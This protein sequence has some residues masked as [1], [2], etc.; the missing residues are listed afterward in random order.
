MMKKLLVLMLSLM[1][2]VGCTTKKEEPVKDNEKPAEEVILGM[3]EFKYTEASEDATLDVEGYAIATLESCTDGDTATFTID[4]INYDTRF[5]AIDTPETSHPT[6]GREPWG[7]PAKEYTCNALTNATQIIIER[8]PVADIFDDYGRLLG[9]VWVDGELLNYKLVEDSLAFVK[10]LYAD[11]EY[12]NAFIQ[13][14][15]I[16]RKA[17]LKI[18]GEKDPD[19]DY[20]NSVIETTLASVREID[21]GKKVKVKGIV[22]AIIGQ[23]MY[24]QDGEH[25]IYIY[26]NK[27]TYRA[28]VVGNEIELTA[29]LAEYKGQLQLANIVDRK[30]EVLSEGN[31]LPPAFEITIDML[32]EDYES[33]LIVLRDLQVITVPEN[34]DTSAGYSVIVSDGTNEGIVRIDKYLDPTIESSFFEE[35]TTID[36]IGVLGQY[37]DEYQIMVTSETNVTRK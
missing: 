14:E 33:R 25:A 7:I 34:A 8:D 16:A 26:A 12:T 32:G 18:H 2:L 21:N 24:I 4:G 11:Y 19:Y 36:V 3:P 13:A 31:E 30:I 27:Y 17:K 15:G 28:A 6:L 29:D 37:N 35:G 5:L 20:D 1:I 10:Y 23:N 22:T 9:W